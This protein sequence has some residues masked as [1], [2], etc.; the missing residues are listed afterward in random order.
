M[1]LKCFTLG[2]YEDR[3]PYFGFLAEAA[4]SFVTKGPLEEVNI[5]WYHLNRKLLNWTIDVKGGHTDRT[6]YPFGEKPYL[7]H[8]TKKDNKLP[9]EADG[10]N[11]SDLCDQLYGQKAIP[12]DLIVDEPT[13]G[14]FY[15][16][17]DQALCPHPSVIVVDHELFR[18]ETAEAHSSEGSAHLIIKGLRQYYGGESH[19]P[20]IFLS[21][22]RPLAG[23]AKLN[24]LNIGRGRGTRISWF[25]R[26]DEKRPTQ[27]PNG[28]TAALREEVN[29]W[30]RNR[31]LLGAKYGRANWISYNPPFDHVIVYY[32]QRHF[33]LDSL[34]SEAEVVVRKKVLSPEK[35][36]DALL[37]RHCKAYLEI[38]KEATQADVE[39]LHG[40]ADRFPLPIV[41]L[42]LN[43]DPNVSNLGDCGVLAHHVEASD[44]N[45]N[46]HMED[47]AIEW[48]QRMVALDTVVGSR[49]LGEVR[50]DLLRWRL[51]SDS[52][53]E[54]GQIEKPRGQ[55]L[56]V[57]GPTGAGKTGISKWCHFYSNHTTDDD[58]HL[59]KLWHDIPVPDPDHRG[60]A[61]TLSDECG[62]STRR[63]GA[64]FLRHWVGKIIE[65]GGEGNSCSSDDN[66][67]ELLVR[68]F[69]TARRRPWQVNLVG[70][71]NHDDFVM[72]MA[73]AYPIWDGARWPD[74]WKAGKILEATNSS[75]ILNEIG[76]L[77]N[78]AQ[79]LLL[80]LV[81]RG[82]PLQ[83]RFAPIG[84]EIEAKNVLFIMATDRVDRIREQ[85]LHR[86]RNIRVPSL[87][88]CQEDIP[89]LARHR[90]LP[91]WCCLSEPAEQLLK[92]WP[93]WPGNH[94][95]LHS[96]L[97]FAA[98][99]L[100]SNR[101]V[102]RI[103]DVIR[104]LWRQ[105]LIRI[106]TRLDILIKW[107]LEWPELDPDSPEGQVLPQV[108]ANLAD[109]T[110]GKWTAFVDNL[111]RIA[112]LVFEN[113][114]AHFTNLLGTKKS[115]QPTDKQEFVSTAIGLLLH[116]V[117][118]TLKKYTS[119]LDTAIKAGKKARDQRLDEIAG[120][121]FERRLVKELQDDAI[122]TLSLGTFLWHVL[123]VRT[124]VI[125]EA[126]DLLLNRPPKQSGRRAKS[127]GIAISGDQTKTD[128]KGETP[129]TGDGGNDG[130]VSNDKTKVANKKEA[131]ST[132]KKDEI[133]SFGGNVIS[134]TASSA[135]R[136][137]LAVVKAID[138][139]FRGSLFDYADDRRDRDYF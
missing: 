111:N 24:T 120:T 62:V 114:S 102:I 65:H 35:D 132:P 69:K 31:E 108:T 124:T 133:P 128:E 11:W 45:L 136:L 20:P 5:L 75:L 83:P 118:L 49:Q 14:K 106:P 59:R 94:R 139:P 119:R 46:K 92:R 8:L 135:S 58:N 87:L 47:A 38:R 15:V 43:T 82:G 121:D 52:T 90:L 19:T 98:E 64:D 116:E 80:E 29:L 122:V 48:I 130:A 138:S 55:A 85:L 6:S 37:A 99:H 16:I 71:T 3:P 129:D 113:P 7:I 41:L 72:Q 76:E 100:P 137:S 50:D 123:D 28:F 60:W 66:L 93:Y 67:S 77:D 57:V 84:G 110:E 134:E 17:E 25:P 61:I 36:A 112:D 63:A 131:S 96:V 95:S 40:L 115:E 126:N 54:E 33:K 2:V 68:A 125:T 22:Y 10:L 18:R 23:E 56:L 97:D 32:E 88:E 78:Q 34:A 1:I 39:R 107:I 21:S 81:E 74:N 86:C 42:Y 9:G 104:A 101:R 12:D 26:P 51:S 109:L 13:P 127:A 105:N 70:V 27:L 79:G 30:V 44:G 89:E 53:R 73:G 103:S 117:F 4:R 91:R